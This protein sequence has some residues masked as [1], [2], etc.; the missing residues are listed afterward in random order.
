M[1]IQ[2]RITH[3][4]T[5]L[6]LQVFALVIDYSVTEIPNHSLKI[7]VS[8]IRF[9]DIQYPIWFYDIHKQIFTIYR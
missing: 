1:D 4:L 2:N 6:S 5:D 7:W 8:E 9:L 3:N